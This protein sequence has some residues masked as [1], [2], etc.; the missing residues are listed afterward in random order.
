MSIY[1]VCVKRVLRHIDILQMQRP[2][3]ALCW[4]PAVKEKSTVK[5]E[6]ESWKTVCEL[7]C[8]IK[9]SS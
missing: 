4:Q 2:F 3:K 5:S 6:G 7:I 1:D 8:A 9:L